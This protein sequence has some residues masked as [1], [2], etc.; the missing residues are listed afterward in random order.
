MTAVAGDVEFVGFGSG[1]GQWTTFVGSRLFR[2]I[3][4]SRQRVDVL[5]ISIMWTASL[6]AAVPII[7]IGS[8]VL[9][10]RS[11][12]GQLT[13][14]NTTPTF[15][16]GGVSPMP[17]GFE[18]LWSQRV[19]GI[20]N[21]ARSQSPSGMS[22][23]PTWRFSPGELSASS[24]QKIFV[25]AFQPQCTDQSTTDIYAGGSAQMS[26]A[27]TGIDYATDVSGSIAGL[28]NQRSYPRFSVPL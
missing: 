8:H 21:P 23:N 11:S 16:A 26:L 12:I 17:A 1:I 9:V 27:V 15:G 10:W 20:H 28:E 2:S 7:A 25:V 24:A 19:S 13:P 5:G 6:G 22:S 14:P 3:F 18:L 4:T